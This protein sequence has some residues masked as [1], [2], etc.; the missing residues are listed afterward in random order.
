[1]NESG[2]WRKI[3]QAAK[4][5]PDTVAW[6]VQDQ[7]NAGLPDVSLRVGEV[8]GYLELKYVKDYPA[9]DSTPI[10]VK[11]SASQRAHLQEWRGPERAGAAFVLL[12]VDQDW[13]L[14]DVSDLFEMADTYGHRNSKGHPGLPQRVMEAVALDY[15]KAV[16]GGLQN[17]FAAFQLYGQP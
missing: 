16:R 7:F 4:R 9:R 5:H 6:K 12:G 14:L 11:V 8:A 1:M 10:W 17:V 13:Y 15:G 2:F 3:R